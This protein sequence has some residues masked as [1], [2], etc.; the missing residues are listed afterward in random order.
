MKRMISP[1]ELLGPSKSYLEKSIPDMEN[2]LLS[3]N[4]E[5]VFGKKYNFF[6][7]TE[8]DSFLKIYP[9]DSNHDNTYWTTAKDIRFRVRDADTAVIYPLMASKSTYFNGTTLVPVVQVPE[10]DGTYTIKL[11]VTQGDHFKFEL[12]K[13]V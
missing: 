6:Q 3:F 10:A 1:E 8:G 5:I 2:S 9:E 7:I 13:D 11:V 4:S 12:V